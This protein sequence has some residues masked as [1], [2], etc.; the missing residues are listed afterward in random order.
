MSANTRIFE[1]HEEVKKEL[2]TIPGVRSVGIGLKE[3]EGQLTDQI[4]FKVYVDEKKPL[5]AL[6]PEHIIPREVRGFKTD[7]I[8][9]A[10]KRLITGAG[11]RPL[12][13]GIAVSSLLPSGV[14]EHGTLGCI[15]KVNGSPN[16]AL[17]SNE[18]VF[19][20]GVAT[21]QNTIFQPKHSDS[22]GFVCNEVGHTAKGKDGNVSFNNGTITADF[23]VDCAIA[24]PDSDIG[25]KNLIFGMGP[26]AGFT[27]ISNLVINDTTAFQV[28]KMGA[29]TGLTV[30]IIEDIAFDDPVGS[31]EPRSLRQIIIRPSPGRPFDKTFRVKADEKATIIAAFA[32][33]PVTITDVGGDKLRFQTI[34]FA[35]GG[36]S[37]SVLLNN[38]NSVVGLVFAMLSVRINTLKGQ[39]IEE[40]DIPVGKAMACHIGPVMEQMQ[41]VIQTGTNPSSGET[42]PRIEN[43]RRREPGDDEGD[44]NRAVRE[45]E[46]Q[47]RAT[48]NGDLFFGI[49]EKHFAKLCTFGSSSTTCNVDLE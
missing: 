32:G 48:P 39:T 3:V 27:D 31:P 9:I 45:V 17:L 35:L 22:L 36:D 4:A 14:Q 21:A 19:R 5:S 29:T 2:E 20:H 6:E 37:G 28:K 26:V 47:L 30:G 8:K 25:T 16:K 23:Y 43:L 18:H 11:P 33:H 7:V 12:V 10:E 40:V 24:T 34:V 46:E 41:V 1:V 13:G 44:I 15:A 49:L 42:L 38:S